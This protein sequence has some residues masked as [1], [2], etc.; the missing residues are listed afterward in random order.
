MNK[1]S[2]VVIVYILG[3]VFG[4]LVL[5]IWSAETSPKALLGIGWTALLLIGLF[6]TENYEKK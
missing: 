5:N 3:L 4:A 6:F 1:S 2:I